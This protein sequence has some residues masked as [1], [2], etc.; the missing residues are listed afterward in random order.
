MS[1]NR[2]R[3]LSKVHTRTDNHKVFGQLLSDKID[4]DSKEDP[5]IFNDHDFYQSLLKDFLATSST[6]QQDATQQDD[7][8]YLDGAD[9]G[10]TQKYLEKKRKLQEASL[11]QRKEVD[12]RASKNRKIRY[13][14]HEK[15]VNFMTGLDR[16]TEDNA[17]RESVLRALFGQGRVSDNAGEEFSGPVRL[18]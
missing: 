2:A 15:L 13:V 8:V 10:M 12:R 11:Q 7:D 14:V 1:E 5:S 17:T 3:L 9:L 16:A 6:T 4:N 18:I